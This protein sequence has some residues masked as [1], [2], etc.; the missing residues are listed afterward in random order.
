MTLRK[1]L[2]ALTF[3]ILLLATAGCDLLE[4]TTD[5]DKALTMLLNEWTVDTVRVREYGFFPAQPPGPLQTPLGRDTLLP[6][7]RMK[8]ISNGEFEKGDLIETSLVNGIEV[9]K[10]IKWH[11]DATKKTLALYYYNTS[12]NAYD[13]GFGYFIIELTDNKL[14]F[15]RDANLEAQNG[16][17]YG[18]IHTLKKMH[19]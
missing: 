10:E 5:E 8:F 6:V 19:K 3:P 9:Q 11:L 13:I 18:S 7:T 1:F 14:H 16:A 15:E 17:R 12:T 2:L 4:P